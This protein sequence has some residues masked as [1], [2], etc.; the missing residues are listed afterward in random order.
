[1][2]HMLI[3]ICARQ[4]YFTVTKNKTKTNVFNI[5]KNQNVI[6][7][8]VVALFFKWFMFLG[9]KQNCI[10][11]YNTHLNKNKK[12]NKNKCLNYLIIIESTK[13]INI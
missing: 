7:N 9:L 6:Y 11:Y 12:K 2:I 8:I 13:I 1:M 10:K 4:R 5:I 3:L